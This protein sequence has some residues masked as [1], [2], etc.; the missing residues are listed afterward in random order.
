MNIKIEL[1][2]GFLDE[3]V[4]CGHVVTAETK[5]IW[6]VELD[7]LAEFIRVCD[8][9]GLK[10]YADGGTL[11]GALR[12]NGYI[13]WDDDID[14]SMM[15]ED[16]EKLCSVAVYE[17]KHP[18]FFQT[19][20]TDPDS[21]FHH[22]KLRNSETSAVSEIDINRSYNQGIWIDIFP[23][24]NIPDDSELPRFIDSINECQEKV[25]M[26]RNYMFD[27]KHKL[28]E[29]ALKFLRHF[30]KHIYVKYIW[31]HFN[32]FNRMCAEYE[33]KIQEYDSSEFG[34]VANLSMNWY[35]FP[36]QLFWHKEWF[37]GERVEKFEF[38]D[39]QVPPMAENLMEKQYGDW[40]KM[41]KGAACHSNKIFDVER[42]Y[43]YYLNGK[44]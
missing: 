43:D 16:Y 3:E 7:L 19:S 34:R 40:H 21:E 25:F 37:E 24:D 18:Y 6:A 39:L 11:L 9:Y 23:L 13:P 42:P 32:P 30:V 29:G 36:K 33:S 38:F 35:V 14:L 2:E 28:G 4:R 17:F 15:R 41:V 1:P 20:S 31:R 8:K 44:S 27:Y 5:K 10:Y 12:H 26:Y 22:A